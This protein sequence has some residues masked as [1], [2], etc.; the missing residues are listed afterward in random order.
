MEGIM[1]NQRI[2]VGIIGCGTISEIYLTNLTTHFKNLEVVA[3]ADMFPEKAVQTQKKFGLSRS[4]TVEELVTDKNIDLV[5]NLTIPGAHYEVNMK[6]LQ[7]GKHVYCEKPL[8]LTYDE[9]NDL[10]E[11]AAKRELIIGSAPDTF[12]GAGLQTCRRLIDQGEIGEPIGF[13]ANLVSPGHELWHPAAAFYYETGGGPMMDMGPYYITALVTLLGPVDKVSC[14][15]KSGR[16]KRMIGQQEVTTKVNTHYTGIMEL[17]TGVTGNVNMSFDVWDSDLPL[18]EIYGTKGVMR[19]P[20][21]NM[22]G[23]QVTIFDGDKMRETVEAVKG[24]PFDR[25][26]KMHHCKEECVKKIESLYPEENIPR[27]NMRGF[28]VADMAQSIIDKRPSRINAEVSKHIV[29]ALTAFDQAAQN[30]A[31]YLMKSTCKRPES[32]P[33]ALELWELS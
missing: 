28:G 27:S 25:I 32:L 20:D 3:C 26:M 29:E 15:A 10:A 18:L 7:A 5:V 21:P 2:G 24:T 8:A 14:F 11:E 33:L 16:K 6:A 23:G 12:L 13:T 22:F 4:L 17:S 31:V 19:V 1:K 30:G 9:A